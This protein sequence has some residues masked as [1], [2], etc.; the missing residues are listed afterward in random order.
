MPSPAGYLHLVLGTVEDWTIDKRFAIRGG[1]VP[2]D[3]VI[4]AIDE[5][6]LQALGPWPFR[7]RYHGALIRRIAAAHPRAVAVDIQFTERTDPTD[8]NALIRAIADAGRVVLATT[9]V[10]RAGRTDVLGGDAIVRQV[11]ARVGDSLVPVDANGVVRRIGWG[12]ATRDEEGS[13]LRPLENLS[14]VAA[15]VASGRPIRRFE[16]LIPIAYVGPPGTIPRPRTRTSCA[17]GCQAARYGQGGRDR[18]LGTVAPGRPRDPFE[19]ATVCRASRS[20]PTRPRRG[21][22]VRRPSRTRSLLLIVLFAFLVLV[23]SLFLRWRWC[24]LGGAVAAVLAS[25]RRLFDHG[26]CSRSRG[27]ALA[28]LGTLPRCSCSPRPVQTRTPSGARLPAEAADREHEPDHAP[29]GDDQDRAPV[30]PEV[31]V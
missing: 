12:S 16:A 9:E 4:V 31:V 21:C 7:R 11:G 15:E 14:L 20:R 6:S 19:L 2:K 3:L 29:E 28:L 8:D 26:G 17:R 22:T 24:L 1:H 10:D 18:P 30:G 23:A 13:P 25:S 5:R 27:R